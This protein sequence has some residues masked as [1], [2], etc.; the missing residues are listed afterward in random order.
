MPV[1]A[2]RTLPWAGE[3]GS[4]P[5]ACFGNRV[6]RALPP[7]LWQRIETSLGDDRDL[8]HHSSRLGVLAHLIGRL[9]GR[10]DSGWLDKLAEAAVLHDIGKIRLDTAILYKPDG[11]TPEDR[12]HIRRHG[13]LGAD[14]LIKFGGDAFGLAAEVARHH[15]EAY[16]GSGYPLGLTGETLPEEARIVALCDVYDALRSPRAYKPAFDHART[17]AILTQGDARTRP[18]QFDPH[19]L[20]VFVAHGAVIETLYAAA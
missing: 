4:A 13:A 7:G 15:H 14:L 3:T 9:A 11:L 5:F 19:L 12:E 17:M 6:F 8:R 20:G 16:D 2:D 10:D 1:V 18:E